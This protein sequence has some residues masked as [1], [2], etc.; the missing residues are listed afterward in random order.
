MIW[1]LVAEEMYYGFI[2]PR[3]KQRKTIHDELTTTYFIA[4]AKLLERIQE[5]HKIQERADKELHEDMTLWF[6]V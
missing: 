4:W 6:L 3:V 5:W 2:F 1:T